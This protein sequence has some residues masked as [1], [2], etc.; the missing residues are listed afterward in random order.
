MLNLENKKWPIPPPEEERFKGENI[1][2]LLK[3][4]LEYEKSV[5]VSEGHIEVRRLGPAA[6]TKPISPGESAITALTKYSDGKIYGGTSGKKAHL[7]FYDPSPDADTV[8]D[9]STV[10]DSISITS[11]VSQDNGYIFGSTASEER[12]GVIFCYIPCGAKKEEKFNCGSFEDIRKIWDTPVEDQIFHSIVDPCH[13]AGEIK[14]LTAPIKGEGI[15]SLVIDNTRNLLYGLSNKKGIFFIYDI[16]EK[17]TRVITQV[18]SLNEF[19]PSLII[20]KEENVY[21]VGVMGK[22]FKYNPEED[23]LKKLNVS[24]PSLKGRELY[25]R[26]DSWKLDDCTG[27]IY[28]GTID[29]ILFRFEPDKEKIISLGKP[30]D[31][32]RIRAITIGNDGRVFGIAGEPGGCAHLFSYDP[33]IHELRDLGVPLATVETPWYGYEFKS[34]VTGKDGEIYFGESD[35]ISHLFIYHPRISKR[36]TV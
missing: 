31:Q 34:A 2:K 22:L 13:S 17:K 8:V 24:I 25:N 5:F 26:V 32:C 19:S 21:G 6:F 15:A 29:G 36:V 27:A 35:R 7:F 1:R 20:D 23:T 33:E 3:L 10:G 4:R 14:V 18:D 16:L 28:G 12:D 9:I 30:I 11:L